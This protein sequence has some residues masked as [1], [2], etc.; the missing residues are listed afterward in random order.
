MQFPD[1]R[2]LVCDLINGVGIVGIFGPQEKESAEYVQSI[3]DT[4]EIPHISIRQDSG[5]PLHLRGL[6]LNLYPHVSAL[7]R[8]SKLEEKQY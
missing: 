4:M 8:V 7:S 3:C 6:G 5:Q 2:R 1:T